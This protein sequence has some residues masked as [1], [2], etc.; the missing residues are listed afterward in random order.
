L[1]AKGNLS[2]CYKKS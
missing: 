2:H 1:T